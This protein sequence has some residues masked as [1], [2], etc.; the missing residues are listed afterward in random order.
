LRSAELLSKVLLVALFLR[1][2]EFEIIPLAV[3]GT[4][5]FVY[6]V[7]SVIIYTDFSEHKGVI[8]KILP[9]LFNVYAR[10]LYLEYKESPLLMSSIH[11][12]KIHLDPKKLKRKNKPEDHNK[13]IKHDT[14][15]QIMVLSM[16]GRR[17]SLIV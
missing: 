1:V 8:L 6:V 11:F 13:L 14:I 5:Y 10:V 16:H 12:K 17:Y 7:F 2:T 9:V 15:G 3:V 4:C